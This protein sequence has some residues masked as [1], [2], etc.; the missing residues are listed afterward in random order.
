MSRKKR[1]WYPGAIYHVMSRGNRRTVLFQDNSDYMR[2]LECVSLSKKQY[3]FRIH[4]MCLMTN[5]FHIAIPLYRL[6][7]LRRVRASALPE[8]VLKRESC[9][10]GL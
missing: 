6:Y 2:F 1:V 5:H 10:L 8:S 7:F 4:S 9:E 3:G